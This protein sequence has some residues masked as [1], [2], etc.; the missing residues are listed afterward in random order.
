M[1][2]MNECKTYGHAILIHLYYY[3]VGYVKAYFRLPYGQT[4]DVVRAHEL[5]KY[6]NRWRITCC[7]VGPNTT[8]YYDCAN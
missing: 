8:N 2:K 3:L 5:T 4:E 7:L 6:H 1:E